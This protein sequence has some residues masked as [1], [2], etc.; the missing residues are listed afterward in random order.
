MAAWTAVELWHTFEGDVGVSLIPVGKG[1][2]EVHVDGELLYDK[3]ALGVAGP[4]R[5]DLS[6]LKM[7][8]HERLEEAKETLKAASG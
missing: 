7:T 8:I 3:K 5:N 4:N 6:Q 2:F 1:R